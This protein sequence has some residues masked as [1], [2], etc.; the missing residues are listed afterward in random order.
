MTNETRLIPAVP[1]TTVPWILQALKDGPRKRSEL[2]RHVD[3]L[4]RLEGFRADNLATLKKALNSLERARRVVKLQYG[5]WD[6]AT[7]SPPEAKRRAA[8]SMGKRSEV[9]PPKLFVGSSTEGL[10]IAKAIQLNLDHEYHE[11]EVTLWSQGVFGLGRGT[12]EELVQEA[13]TVDFAVLVLTPDDLVTKREKGG[14]QPRDNVLFELG[15]FMG[16]LGRDR[17]FIVHERTRLLDL[18]TDLAGITLAT[19]ARRADNNMEA[20]LGPVCT[21]LETAMRAAKPQ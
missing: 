5:W 12:L 15:L 19:F 3:R 6:L 17:T 1:T 14:Q 10:S 7:A 21:R 16:K 8:P 9:K 11:C 13:A 2:L 4:A 18:P 20:A